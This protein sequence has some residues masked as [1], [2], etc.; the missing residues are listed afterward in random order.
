MSDLKCK[1]PFETGQTRCACV[2]HR[3]TE[4][5]EAVL[6]DQ[7]GYHA[8]QTKE[9]ESLRAEI[10]R[11]NSC[12]RYEQH[13]AE[14]IGTHGPGCETWGPAHY[15]CAVQEIEKL[16][17]S[18]ADYEEINE[19]YLARIVW[20][21]GQLAASREREVRMRALIADDSYAMTFQS[22]GQYRTALLR[23]LAEGAQLPVHQPVHQPVHDWE[24]TARLLDAA[25]QELIVFVD[26]RWGDN[27]CRPLENAK[28]ALGLV[29]DEQ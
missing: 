2:F 16:Q 13:R 10:E 25:L 5:D 4:F 27:E 9:I 21:D 29:K 18:L 6:A 12:L 3:A 19:K 11:L 26:D 22:F 8:T 14:R 15:E 20:L 23:A 7:C 28:H 17:H 24:H 1:G